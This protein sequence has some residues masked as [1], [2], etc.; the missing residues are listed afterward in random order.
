MTDTTNTNTNTNTDAAHAAAL[1]MRNAAAALARRLPLYYGS[2]ESADEDLAQA[3]EDLPLPVDTTDWRTEAE[4]LRAEVARLSPTEDEIRYTADQ[5]WAGLSGATAWHL[6]E[7]HG[8]GWAGIGAMMEAWRDAE[9]QRITAGL[10]ADLARAQEQAQAER[11]KLV[12]QKER[13]DRA[14]KALTEIDRLLGHDDADD[15]LRG[16]IDAV[17]EGDRLPVYAELEQMTAERDAA[18]ADLAALRQASGNLVNDIDG[19]ISE[20]EGVA[21]LHLNGDV[22]DWGV[23][24]PGGRFERLSALDDVRALAAKGD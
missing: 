20:S 10:A 24:V 13:G 17:L 7:R 18:L 19:L 23:L 16:I 6:A 8:E 2:G 12:L 4:W 9:V 3:I 14:L 1:A 15:G 22:A 11:D 5:D 21:G